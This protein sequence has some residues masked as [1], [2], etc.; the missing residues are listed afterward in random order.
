MMTRLVSPSLPHAEANLGRQ[1]EARQLLTQLTEAAKTRYLHPYAFAVVHLALGEKD[2][3]LETDWKEQVEG[4]ARRILI[5]SKSILTSIRCGAIL[6]LKRLWKKLAAK[7][8]EGDHFLFKAEAVQRLQS[9]G[10]LLSRCLNLQRKLEE[11]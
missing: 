9:C 5:L 1:T 6:A 8:H 10:F 2:Q 3:T 11:S 7:N 4:A